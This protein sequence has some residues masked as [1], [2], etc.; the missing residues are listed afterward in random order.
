MIFANTF[1]FSSEDWS[2][3]KNSMHCICVYDV[4]AHTFLQWL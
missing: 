1:I 2:L 4:L 3:L